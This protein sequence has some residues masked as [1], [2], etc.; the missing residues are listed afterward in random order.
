MNRIP[1]DEWK[2]VVDKWK[3]SG[4]T[5][6]IFCG[7]CEDSPPPSPWL[8]E[9]CDMSTEEVISTLQDICDSAANRQDTQDG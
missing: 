6:L 1:Y 8:Q 4:T 9:I 5:G 3:D 2:A 7:H